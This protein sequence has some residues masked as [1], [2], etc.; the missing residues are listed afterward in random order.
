[1]EKMEKNLTENESFVNSHGVSLIELLVV[2]AI[3]AVLAVISTRGVLL[4]LR[5]S[6]KSESV[7]I[8]RENL[9]FSFA[10]MERR[11]RNAED[12]TCPSSTRV[13]Y[14]DSL[15]GATYFSCESIGT[16]GYIS[17]G[18]AR[19]TNKNVSVTECEFTCS[20]PT[21]GSPPSV[22]ISATAVEKNVGGIE[23]ASVTLNTKI[24][25]RSY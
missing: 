11:L 7:A 19:L 23:G 5:G 4:S 15:S 21:G 8:V 24:F 6:K 12:A 20:A 13:D 25:L 9:D 3:F 2:I 14:V 16:E 1:M 17:S 18:S 22:N 10:V